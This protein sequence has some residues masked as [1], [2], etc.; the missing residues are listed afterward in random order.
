MPETVIER[1]KFMPSPQNISIMLLLNTLLRNYWF[2]TSEVMFN[3]APDTFRG[4]FLQAM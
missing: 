3:V 1:Q 2:N 4:R